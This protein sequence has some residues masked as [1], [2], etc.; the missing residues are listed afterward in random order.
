MSS[1]RDPQASEMNQ[2]NVN[3]EK[4]HLLDNQT[5][6]TLPAKPGLFELTSESDMDSEG[7]PVVITSSAG[8]VDKIRNI[9][10]QN[11]LVIKKMDDSVSEQSAQAAC[12]NDSESIEKPEDRDAR[13]A[14]EQ[15]DVNTTNSSQGVN[16]DTFQYHDQSV[17]HDTPAIKDKKRKFN[18]AS[19]E[20]DKLLNTSEGQLE[21]QLN[22]NKGT[23]SNSQLFPVFSKKTTDARETKDQSKRD[24][25][26][27][28]PKEQRQVKKKKTKATQ[29]SSSARSLKT[30][31]CADTLIEGISQSNLEVL[32]VRTVVTLYNKVKDLISQMQT[33]Q[34]KDMCSFQEDINK[35]LK[36]NTK[37]IE[38]DV[39]KAMRMYEDRIKQMEDKLDEF[40]TREHLNS[41]LIQYQQQVIEDLCKRLDDVDLN[42]VKKSAILSGLC[43]SSE[44]NER[45]R[46][47]EEFFTDAIEVH[48]EVEDSYF[49]S[50][51]NTKSTVIIFTSAR[52]K[53]RVFQE[54]EALNQIEG[55]NGER[56]YINSYLPATLNERK[57]RQR[58]IVKQIKSENINRQT[59]VNFEVLRTGLLIGSTEYRKKIEAPDP[60]SILDLTSED[61]NNQ[62]RKDVVKGLHM[63]VKDSIFIPYSA[64]VKNYQM[65]KDVYMKVRLM[66][67]RAKHIVC[68]YFLPGEDTYN[69][70]DYEDNGDFGA[71]RAV[72]K[73]MVDNNIH[74]KAFFIVRLCGKIKLQKERIS[75]YVK[76]AAS[77]MQLNSFNSLTGTTQ[78]YKETSTGTAKK[79]KI[80]N[81]VGGLKKHKTDQNMWLDH[82]VSGDGRPGKQ[83]VQGNQNPTHM[84]VQ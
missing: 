2:P 38:A 25:A 15:N 43:F 77:V 9:F 36:D 75:S 49:L 44:K 22:T 10:L 78:S 32:D 17:D 59:P 42:N 65:I 52:D 51:T 4:S 71:G 63:R 46:Q 73:F 57:R 50:A 48:V 60:T 47:I 80:K 5:K 11:S 6:L 83:V 55:E 18:S 40:K 34:K 61:L 1:K 21:V 67:A 74:H 76:A 53:D 14:L 8:P 16:H 68:A 12:L 58:D 20:S 31:A 54:K 72:L 69:A 33:D 3:T 56:I 37:Q 35:R 28:E 23:G 84:P 19:S 82:P 26:T 13:S 45:N 27:K 30:S 7:S 24:A 41:E 64:D 70:R 66:H 79:E 29:G 39:E 81:L 62:L